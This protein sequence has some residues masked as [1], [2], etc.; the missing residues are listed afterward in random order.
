MNVET[1]YGTV[2]GTEEDGVASFKGIP[3]G[4]DT[5][6]SRRFRPPMP[7]PA[8]E[9]VRDCLEYGPSCPQLT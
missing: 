6:G 4:D 2:R 8:W 1:R 7:A 9:D 5:A 3:Y